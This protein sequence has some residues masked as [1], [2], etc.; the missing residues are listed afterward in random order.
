V[1]LNVPGTFSGNTVIS[2]G[3]LN[4]GANQTFANLSGK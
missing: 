1:T 4:L 3:A 2:N